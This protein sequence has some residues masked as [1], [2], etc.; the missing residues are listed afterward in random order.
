V[1]AWCPAQA[2]T[3]APGWIATIRDGEREVKEL[4]ALPERG[5]EA[6]ETPHP[7][8]RPS[9]T[10]TY[11]GFLVIAQAGTYTFDTAG[12]LSLGGEAVMRW[13]ATPARPFEHLARYAFPKPNEV[14]LQ[15]SVVARAEWVDFEVQIASYLDPAFPV[16]E[17]FAA[18]NTWVS[19]PPRI[20][21]W[22]AFP[23][24]ADPT[25]II[26]DGCWKQGG[27]PVTFAM[28]EPYAAP[29]SIRRHADGKFA[30]VFRSDPQDAF[31]LYTARDGDPHFSSYHA[32]FG[33]TILAGTTAT[34]GVTLAIGEWTTAE[35]GAFLRAQGP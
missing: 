12:K 23:R 9:F 20:G 4:V 35:I 31:A 26:H 18:N 15:V 17:V 27:A 14:A 33:R 13:L 22:H 30:A 16:A 32:L 3:H 10:V 5:R 7:A 25:A 1:V 21:V 11:E 24:D 19:S 28:R 29:L 8:I 6:E 34:A 2:H